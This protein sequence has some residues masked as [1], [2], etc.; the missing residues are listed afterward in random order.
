MTQKYPLEQL[1]FIKKKKLEEAEKVL[2]DKKAL[3]VEEEKKLHSLR[4]ERDKV[5][6]HKD[7][8][9]NQ[10]REALDAGS[11]TTK[12]EQMRQYLK[13]VKE[14]LKI[15]QKHVDDQNKKVKE[16]QDQVEIARRQ[17]IEKQKN[18]EK[19]AVHQ[20]EWQKERKRKEEHKE[21]IDY[22]EMGSA[23]HIIKKKKMHG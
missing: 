2:R 7:L 6:Q 10:M 23:K 12:I 3:L 1:S 22:D 18:V 4:M 8:K 15:K 5:E 19:L 20:K 16:A 14:E 13:L 21:D 9:L 17:L 11:A